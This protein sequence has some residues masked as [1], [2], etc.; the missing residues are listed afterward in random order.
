[1]SDTVSDIELKR[2]PLSEEI[3]PDIFS[4]PIRELDSRRRVVD[5]RHNTNSGRYFERYLVQCDAGKPSHLRLLG[6]GYNYVGMNNDARN[7]Y[8]SSPLA[9]DEAI[10][11]EITS[12]D[13]QSIAAYV[14]DA[15]S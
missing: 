14:C 3:D 6:E 4:A 7:A 10:N 5:T 13:R 9:S 8:L 2:I 15:R 1:M 11:K 12:S